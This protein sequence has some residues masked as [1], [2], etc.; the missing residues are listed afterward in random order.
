MPIYSYS[1]LNMY[2]DCPLKYKLRYRD[3]IKRDIEGIEAFLGSRV[4]ET[5]Q[6]CYNDLRYNKVN[7][8]ADLLNYYNKIWQKNWNDS[9]VITKEGLTQEH[10]RALGEKLI[11]NYYNRYSPFDSDITIDTEMNIRFS[12]DDE[13]KYRMTG[14]IDRL[15]RTNDDVYEIHDYKTSAHLPTQEDADSDRQLALYHIGIQKR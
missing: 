15:S 14:Y 5:L 13:D 3:K 1:Q 9:I 8:L 6:K 12:L 10:Y 7:S 11:R 4:H 2:K